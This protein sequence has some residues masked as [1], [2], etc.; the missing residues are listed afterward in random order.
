MPNR[1]TAVPPGPAPNLP[2]AL[3]PVLAV[4]DIFMGIMLS[5]PDGLS[6]RR[7]WVT[8]A[9]V[10]LCAATTVACAVLAGL[11]AAHGGWPADVAVGSLIVIVAGSAA[12]VAVGVT[13]RLV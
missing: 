2:G 9:T 6:L 10:G 13:Q 1:F 12:V 4:A 5:R 7:T 8:P 11:L 3:G